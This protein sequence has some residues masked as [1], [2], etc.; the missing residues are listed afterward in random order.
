MLQAGNAYL[1]LFQYESPQGTPADPERNP[2]SH[3]YTHFCIDVT[4]ID[5]E[6]ARLSESGM[7]FHGPPPTTD[8]LGHGALRAIYGRDPDGNIIELQEILDPAVPFALEHTTMI[9]GAAS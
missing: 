4:D 7:T 2:A 9:G 5:A 8:E 3:G 6:Y 1:E